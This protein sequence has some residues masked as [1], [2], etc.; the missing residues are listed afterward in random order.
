[1][2]K[3]LPLLFKKQRGFTLPELL[4]GVVLIAV[5]L[6]F[7]LP[8][9]SAGN[10]RAKT[11]KCA[12]NLRQI[13]ALLGTFIADKGYYPGAFM[14]MSASGS[15]TYRWFQALRSYTDSTF[16]RN[17]M[18]VPPVMRCP[19]RQPAT[20]VKALGY[21]YNFEGFGHAP[22]REGGSWDTPGRE[23]MRKYWQIRPAMVEEPGQKLVIGD[24]LDD[25][26]AS[27]ITTR[28][29]FIYRGLNSPYH[30]RR[31][32]GGGNY[33]FADGHVEWLHVEELSRRVKDA[34]PHPFYP[35]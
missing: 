24:S 20:G 35:F 31:H 11:T 18:E 29:I 4:V 19:S 28:V 3:Q 5:I 12:G 13:G 8:V 9:L 25:N 33:L 17:S 16:P 2:T 6:A 32:S 26:P 27:D 30:A 23:Y 21:G 7:M 14:E 1:M 34:N 15:V 10:E 22:N